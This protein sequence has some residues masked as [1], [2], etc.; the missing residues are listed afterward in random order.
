MGWLRWK[1]WFNIRVVCGWDVA[2]VAKFW[3][4]LTY[5]SNYIFKSWDIL[6]LINRF[7]LSKTFYFRLNSLDLWSVTHNCQ[8]FL[9]NCIWRSRP[10]VSFIMIFN[11]KQRR[12][13]WTHFIKRHRPKP[14]AHISIICLK[15]A[16]FISK[17]LNDFRWWI[18]SRFDQL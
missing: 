9:C 8:T 3:G 1:F 15:G 7:K 12:R 13:R 16:R 18:L 5:R 2:S 4:V 10:T 11:T 17:Y 6:R 14:R